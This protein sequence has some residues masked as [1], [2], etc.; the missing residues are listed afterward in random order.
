MIELSAF[1]CA[2][3]EQTEGVLTCVV[4]GDGHPDGD[5]QP[6]VPEDRPEDR[7]NRRVH[8]WLLQPTG[9]PERWRKPADRTED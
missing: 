2:A 8:G 4:V 9:T 6:A 1:G 3:Q 7:G 5:S